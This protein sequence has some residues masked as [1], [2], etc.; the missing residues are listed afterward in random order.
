MTDR[1]S[2]K[3]LSRALTMHRYRNFRIFN[4][5]WQVEDPFF[6]S[7]KGLQ[8]YQHENDQDYSLLL[9]GPFNPGQTNALSTEIINAIVGLQAMI[10]EDQLK[11]LQSHLKETLKK[12]GSLD[13]EVLLEFLKTLSRE[14]EESKVAGEIVTQETIRKIRAL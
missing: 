4:L 14:C 11:K 9:V 3:L 1:T 2:E 7:A 8:D 13:P 6:L 10:C 12:R 5:D